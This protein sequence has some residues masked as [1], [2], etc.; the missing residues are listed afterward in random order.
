MN[1]EDL[2]FGGTKTSNRLKLNE[3]TLDGQDGGFTYKKLLD[4]KGEDGFY[5][6]VK[7]VSKS[8]DG[9]IVLVRRKLQMFVDADN[10]TYQTNEF[11]KNNEEITFYSP[12]GTEKGTAET[13]RSKYPTLKTLAVI[14]FYSPKTK[15][16]VRLNC[17]GLGLQPE[18]N[19]GVNYKGLFEYLGSFDEGELP[20]D[21]ITTVSMVPKEVTKGRKTKTYYAMRFGR[22]DLI[23]NEETLSQVKQLQQ[24]ALGQFT[25]EEKVENKESKFESTVEDIKYPEEQYPEEDINVEAIS[26]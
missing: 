9:V 17:K 15:E 11:N 10:K 13:L 1:K 12:K 8:I 5:P 2:G 7:I 23:E 20:S 4:P 18:D 24:K 14:Y 26:F 6:V 16:M 3:I 25:K 22:G 19:K 21:F